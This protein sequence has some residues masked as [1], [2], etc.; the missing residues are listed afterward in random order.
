MSE[1]YMGIKFP[2]SLTDIVKKTVGERIEDDWGVTQS[3]IRDLH[4]GW[5]YIDAHGLAS[6]LAE[7]GIPCTIS[8]ERE[9]EDEQV[10]YIH[11]RFIEG[12]AKITDVYA[13]DFYIALTDLKS[14]LE[15]NSHAEVTVWVDQ[16]IQSTEEPSWDNQEELGKQYAFIKSLEK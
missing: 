1:I 7:L 9:N 8:W 13:E 3:G 10:N 12:K 4:F 14:K 6:E 5:H 11:V 16:M 2:D 15:L